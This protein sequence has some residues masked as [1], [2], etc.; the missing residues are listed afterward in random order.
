MRREYDV[1]IIGGGITGTA[2]A[3]ELSRYSSSVLLLEQARDISMGATRANS[4]IVHGGYS[5]PIGSL[6]AQ[7]SL[8]GNRMYRQLSEEL[9]FPYRQTGSY[10]LACSEEEQEVLQDLLENGRA[11]GEEQLEIHTSKQV[12]DREPLVSTSVR[13]ALR[14]SSAGIVSPYEA[15]AGFMENA[16]TNGAVLRLRS[17]AVSI[18]H[19]GTRYRVACTLPDGET[20]VF[21]APAVL[22]AAGLYSDVISRM[23]GDDSFT[24]RPRKGEYLLLRRGSAEGIH[25]V[26]FQTPSSKGKGVLVTPT[27]WGNLLIGPN[28]QDTQDREDTGSSYEQ[29]AGIYRQALKTVPSLDLSALIRVFS[30]VRPASDRK[31]FIIGEGTLPGF[32]QAA[33]IE[34][35]GLTSAPAAAEMIREAMQTAGYIGARKQTFHALRAPITLPGPLQP[36]KEIKDLLDLPE[37]DPERVVCRCEQ[38]RERTIADALS[39]GIPIDSLDAVKRRTRAGMGQCQG[40]FCGPRVTSLV[41]GIT[42]LSAQEI[43]MPAGKDREL[44]KE[45]KKLKPDM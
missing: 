28:A 35:P 9:G 7:L 23:A 25:S 18:E 12:T 44:L 26:L 16:L 29:L 15:A 43:E 38:V 36:M 42:G 1:I 8:R 22:N 11:M 34:S 33:G 19:T 40:A 37:G 10:V 24:I 39:R 27:T 4:G 31:D 5:S 21:S 6:K 20:A 13:E 3:R 45:L 41:M 17:K 30:G 14:C 2:A 32:F